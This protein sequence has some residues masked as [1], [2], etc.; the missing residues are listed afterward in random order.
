RVDPGDC[1]AVED[2]NTGAKSAEAAG[3]LVLVV[4]HQVPVLGGERRVFRDSLTG[5]DVAG[6]RSLRGQGGVGY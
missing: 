3:C 6:L 2:S 4:P 1:L 5:L